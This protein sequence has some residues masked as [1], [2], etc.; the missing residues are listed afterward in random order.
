MSKAGVEVLDRSERR[1]LA[2]PSVGQRMRIT[3]YKETH[4]LLT[5]LCTPKIRG[6][7][8]AGSHR[9]KTNNAIPHITGSDT[10]ILRSGF[11]P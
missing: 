8:P 4:Q 10:M 9:L 3:A 1:P 5:A 11:T 2:D 7:V 6:N